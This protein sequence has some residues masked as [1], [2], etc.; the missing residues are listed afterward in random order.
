MQKREIRS[1]EQAAAYLTAV[2]KFTEKHSIGE[3]GNFLIRLGR[4]D[5]GLPVI[6]V[7]GTNGKGSVCAYLRSILEASGMRTAVFTSP[8]L[9][10]IRER[11]VIGGETVSKEDF[12][13]AFLEVYEALDWEALR[14][15]R[16]YH[17]TFFEYLFFMAMLLFHRA[18][19][20]CCILETGLGGRLDA[21]NAV[22]SKLV[23]VITRISRDHMEYLG[24]TVEAIAGEKAGI[25]AAGVPAVF[26]EEEPAA[27]VLRA[28]A[29]Q[30]GCPVFPVSKADYRFSKI[31]NKNIDFSCVSRYYGNIRLCLGTSARYQM[32]NCTLAVRTLDA[33]GL[34]PRIPLKE[35]RR[36]VRECRWAGRMEEIL[37]GVYVDG[38]HN[39]DGVRAF[40]ETV[41]GD[42][43]AGERSLLFAAAADKEYGKMLARIQASGLFGRIALVRMANGRAASPEAMGKVLEDVS[44]ERPLSF[45]TVREALDALLP[46]AGAGG[47]L[48]IA[49]SLYLAGEVKGVLRI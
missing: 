22:E 20:D 28:R 6:H 39:E 34:G 45:D 37:P 48:Y 12:L 14:E 26:L 41:A 3:T 36:G 11:F 16:G 43:F 42:G 46:L 27:S 32:E 8:H 31:Q 29:A 2:P 17:P 4:P 24:D 18:R 30:L 21:T 33:L 9:T 40:L 19:P 15:D 49:G 47:R 10:D 38:A 44:G 5:R 7:A 23:S 1:F 35:L 25:L 13:G